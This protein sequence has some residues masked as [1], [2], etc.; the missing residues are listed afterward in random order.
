MKD[1]LLPSS[2]EKLLELILQAVSELVDFELAVILKLSDS[3]H[4]VVQKAVGPLAGG[5]LLTYKIDL[6]QRKDI[7]RILNIN[8][9]YLFDE[10]EEHIDT[11]EEILELPEGHSCMVSPLYIKD[12]PIGLLTL[13]HSVCGQFSPMIV[14]I[15]GTLSRLI[16]IIIDQNESGQY[17]DAERK[18]LTRERNLLLKNNQSEFR[19]LIGSSPTWNIVLEQI[20]TV[21]ES[22]L[23]V[24]IHGETGTGKEQAAKVIH[25]LSS[26]R[27]APF[28]TLNCSALN[29][30]LA[31]SE[32]FGHEQGAFTSANS[33]RRGRFELADGGTLFLDE[34]ADLPAEIQPKILR[35]LQE[36]TFERVGGEKTLSC[37]VRVI[38]ASNKNLRT[39]VSENR[40]REDL[41]YRLG[42]FPVNLPPLRDRR[43]DIVPLA[44]HFLSGA[45][46]G[47]S[48]ILGTEALEEMLRYPWP[49]NIRELQ[50]VMRRAALLA[51]DGVINV[52]HL[53]LTGNLSDTSIVQG[54]SPAK[55]KKDGFPTLQEVETS[56]IRKALTASGGKIYGSDGAAVLLGL[57]PSTLQSRMNKLGIS[58][59]SG[60]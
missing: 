39:E 51:G 10:N 2:L 1:N 16:A 18:S 38:A 21:A 41:Y 25:S 5:D 37:N 56:H 6:R 47:S 60:S 29:A 45:G 26:R 32:L 58:K 52:H 36:G 14:D 54:E 13:D 59:N 44:E 31:E 35:T 49:G 27:D 43:E 42:V 8:E 3:N 11:Y 7:A 23:P 33:R 48:A 22:D 50:N 30:G 4:L 55:E 15:I 17:L 20:R 19:N 57:K 24:L 34:I 9:P 40:F 12:Q 46:C 28:I 53:G